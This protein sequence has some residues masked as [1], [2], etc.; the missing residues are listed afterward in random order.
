MNTSINCG[1]KGQYKVDVFRG[2]GKSREF[3]ESTNWFS[4]DITNVGLNYPFIYPFA[5]C[6]MF[7]SIGTGLTAPTNNSNGT[8][9]ATGLGSFSVYNPTTGGYSSQ[10]GQYIGW[11]GYEIGGP[12]DSTYD[13]S[14]SS[15][16]GTVLTNQGVNLYRGWTIPTGSYEN[17]N[18]VAQDMTINQF[19]TS[20][21]SGSDVNGNKAFSLVSR[22]IVVPSGYSATITYQLSINFSN[23]QSGYTF[24]SGN[25][26]TVG[27][28]FNTGNAS[29]GA[30][31]SNEF[32]LLSGWSKLSGIYRQ[33]FPAIQLIDG[34][35][36]CVIPKMGS[37]L[38]PSKINCQ[39]SVFYLS[40]D[41]SQF[42]V[43]K[44]GGASTGEYGAYNSYGLMAN[45]AE[46]VSQVGGDLAIHSDKEDGSIFSDANKWYYSGDAV[47]T[48]DG[49][50]QNDASTTEAEI[51]T[52][53][54]LEG[55]IPISNYNSGALPTSSLNYQ[56]KSYIGA[57]NLPVAFATPGRLGFNGSFSDYGQKAVYSSCLKRLPIS[58]AVTG[59][60]VRG[61]YVTKRSI[62]SPI[63]S[64]GTNSRYG[65]LTL[66]YNTATNA[67]GSADFHPYIDFLFFDDQGRGANMPHYRL[68][69]D[70]YL[71]ERGSGV[72]SVRFDI[73]GA[74]GSQP[75]SINRFW[76]ADG[77][78]G[79]GV[80]IYD[81]VSGINMSQPLLNQTVYQG[82]NTFI[83]PGDKV[84][85]YLFTGQVLN[86]NVPGDVTYNSNTGWGSV[87][88]VV[89]S[90][91]FYTSQIDT[92]LAD[93]P[94]WTGFS[95][96]IPN[97][98]GSNV[99]WPTIG[100]GIGLRITGVSY[101]CSGYGDGTYSGPLRDEGVTI[102]NDVLYNGQSVIG[103]IY[104]SSTLDSLP[105]T[106]GGNPSISI[107]FLGNP[108]DSNLITGYTLNA[109]PYTRGSGSG[110]SLSTLNGYTSTAT[111]TYYTDSDHLNDIGSQQ[112][113]VSAVAWK[114]PSGVIRHVE[115]IDNLGYRLLPNYANP[116]NNGVNTYLPVTGGKF[117]GMSTQN[118]MEL[119]LTLSWTGR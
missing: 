93:N 96:G 110:V 12:H 112:L 19:M 1:L 104:M 103:S 7:L 64:Y 78:M 114:K 68:I 48:P 30:N 54:R 59:T 65:S 11:E 67:I 46:F 40:P 91:G 21:S 16:C 90:T 38:E 60:G 25:G 55:M 115:N 14:L 77:F 82:T 26:D 17:G 76:T 31:G 15:A 41:I 119:Y 43:N 72:A 49:S 97:S 118:G 57:K 116:N 35:G 100:S 80:S 111:A 45:Y 79:N 71:V 33:I 106:N 18:V 28:Y 47:N 9:L 42:A 98:T 37:D 29:T 83:P 6:F 66:A 73:T 63:N 92:C 32:E 3:V 86:E 70:I 62:F 39:K 53:I 50:S 34:V 99:Y 23:Y 10:S 61:K 113:T 74:N 2:G 87:Y 27:G 24:F 107:Q 81:N 22:T 109:T 102:I 88:G 56:T 5:K 85:G 95:G 36:A 58:A 8:G 101:I 117:P 94:S 51:L 108:S 89:A 13:G 69:P 105:F 75:S 52:N 84:A 44:F 20:P 4:N